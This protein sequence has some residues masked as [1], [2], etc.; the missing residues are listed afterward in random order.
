MAALT[1][2]LSILMETVITADLLINKVDGYWFTEIG[3]QTQNLLF[4]N[5]FKETSNS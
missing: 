2:E 1:S 5:E 4:R 3:T